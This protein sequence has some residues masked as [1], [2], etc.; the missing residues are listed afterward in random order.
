[1]SEGSW[2]LEIIFN[3]SF[4]I[5]PSSIPQKERDAFTSLSLIEDMD[6]N[7]SLTLLLNPKTLSKNE[8]TLQTLGT[9]KRI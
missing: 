9:I 3:I 2:G 1:M 4:R 8:L 6:S 5:Y 7:L